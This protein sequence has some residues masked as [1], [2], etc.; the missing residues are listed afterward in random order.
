MTP[1]GPGGGTDN[2]MDLYEQNIRVR[3]ADTGV[4]GMIKPVA[5]LNI[6][7]D[8]MSR[9]CGR[10]GASSNDLFR[11]GF[12]WVVVK[13]HIALHHY[14]GWND[15]LRAV[16][17][18]YPHKNLYELREFEIYDDHEKL[19]IA[20]RSCW[21]V[22]S[23][24]GKKPVRLSKGLP[25]AMLSGCQRPVEDN[26]AAIP[27]PANTDAERIFNIRM[28]DLDFNT[29]VNNSVYIVWALETVPEA[30]IRGYR[31]CEIDIHYIGES[32]YGDRIISR[33]QQVHENPAPQFAHALFSKNTGKI[34]TR[35]QTVWKPFN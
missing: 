15:S 8:I 33:A 12:A 3:Y 29:H 17:W 16:T 21:I 31:P 28:H 24:A 14:P 11:N 2:L 4:R 35:A 26:F 6:F 5:A 1:P 22:V 18:R 32:L 27:E 9:H 25:E 23:L 10:M 7:Q 19:L 34:I 13:Y 20:A 30:V